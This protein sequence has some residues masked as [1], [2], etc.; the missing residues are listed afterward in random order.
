MTFP[1]CSEVKIISQKLFFSSIWGNFVLYGTALL[2]LF[3]FSCS[4]LRVNVSNYQG[5]QLIPIALH[6]E[7]SVDAAL[8]SKVN[9]RL[10]T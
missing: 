5:Y 7:R 2:P 10:F 3:L 4:W 1:T 6:I 9:V 8:L